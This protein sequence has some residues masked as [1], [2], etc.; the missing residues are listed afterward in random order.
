MDNYVWKVGFQPFPKHQSPMLFYSNRFLIGLQDIPSED[1]AL[2]I[3]DFK[4]SDGG[5]KSTQEYHEN[6]GKLDSTIITCKMNSE[7]KGLS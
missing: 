5:G 6:K 3:I 4:G 7:G 1:P 2:I